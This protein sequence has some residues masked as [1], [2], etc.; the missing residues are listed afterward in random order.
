MGAEN[1]CL[2]PQR[3]GCEHVCH[4]VADAAVQ[5]ECWPGYRKNATHPNKCSGARQINLSIYCS[6]IHTIF[7]S[8]YCSLEQF[9]SASIVHVHESGYTRSSMCAQMWTSAPSGR[10]TARCT[11]A[12]RTRAARSAACAP[13]TAC[14]S[15]ASASASVLLSPRLHSTRLD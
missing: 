14:S 15:T 2:L 9:I 3:G 1:G 10:T 5:C 4:L 11:R 8:Q 6:S 13:P 12:A 7:C